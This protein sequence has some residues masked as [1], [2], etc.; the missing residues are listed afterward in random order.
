MIADDRELLRR[1]FLAEGV[2]TILPTDGENIIVFQWS[3]K[4]RLAVLLSSMLYAPN[5]HLTIIMTV[6]HGSAKYDC[7]ILG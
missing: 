4:S 6:N 7:A 2:S 5:H 3:I 1:L